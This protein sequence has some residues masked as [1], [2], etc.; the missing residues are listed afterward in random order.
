LPSLYLF[1]LDFVKGKISSEKHRNNVI[2]SCTKYILRSRSRATPF[3][4]FSAIGMV[5]W[6]DKDEVELADKIDRK[7][8]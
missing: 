7:R 6:G 8:V 5:Q 1:L 4:L 3:G 2:Q